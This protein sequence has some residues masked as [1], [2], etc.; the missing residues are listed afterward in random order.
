MTEVAP[1]PAGNAT[2]YEAARTNPYVFIVGCPRSGTTLLGRMVDAHPSLAIVH[3]SRWIP[4]WYQN[5]VG[6]TRDGCVTE[7]FISKLTAYKRFPKL[8]LDA[9]ELE[10]LFSAK[11]PMS[12][13]FFT[14][15][16]F[17]LYGRR[18][19]KPL[20]GDKT[21]RYVRDIPTLHELFPAAR[22]VHIIRDGRDVSLSIME[23]SKARHTV[24]GF[25]SYAR[26]PVATAALWWEWQVR[27]GREAGATLRGDLYHELRYESLVGDPIT[28]CRALCEFLKVPFEESMMRFH[29]G[30]TIHDS[31]LDAKKAWLP[32]TSGLRDWRSQMTESDLTSFEANSGGL[33]EALGYE[34]VRSPL[35]RAKAWVPEL[36]TQFAAELRMRGRRVPAKWS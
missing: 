9:R 26:D 7:K 16:L 18:Q 29:E 15:A 17:D 36:R 1:A 32:V 4:T 20:V 8:G 24:G 19:D 21:P 5:R 14:R 27:L 3:E 23:W 2:P 10:K 25:S 33:L 30:K 35:P 11:K 12:Y 6:L 34:I 22:F 31:G 28:T 13:A